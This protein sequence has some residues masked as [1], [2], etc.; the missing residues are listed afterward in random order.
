MKRRKPNKIIRGLKQ[1]VSVAK[2]TNY[3][4]YDYNIDLKKW[5][6]EQAF[7]LLCTDDNG[8]TNQADLITTA[9]KIYNWVKP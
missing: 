2:I 3:V 8:N 5:C 6:I 7:G 4:P 9:E 1:A